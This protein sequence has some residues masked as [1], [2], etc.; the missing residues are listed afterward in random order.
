MDEITL[1]PIGTV[2]CSNLYKFEAPRQ[3]IYASGSQAQIHLEKDPGLIAALSDLA[4][5]ERIWVLF[6]FHQNHSWKPKVT[7]PVCGNKK[8]YGVFATRSPHRPNPI[9]LSCVTL[10]SVQENI[11][12]IA[13]HDL[14]DG[15]PVLDIKPYIPQVDSFPDSKAGWRDEIG[16]PVEVFF[17]EL[18]L[19]KSA[20]LQELCGL[21]LQNFCA[22]QLAYDPVSDDRKRV[23]KNAD[24]SYNIG[25]R[26]WQIRFLYDGKRVTVL[27]LFSHY[28]AEE[29]LP[30]SEDPYG[31]KEFH[32]T[33]L[34]EYDIHV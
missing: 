12:Q 18:F 28:T 8:R 3:G 16:E 21:S 6:L 14:L 17:E 2:H 9:G 10:L 11:L 26:T 27:D 4:G 33:F 19:Q 29:L 15:T 34:R 31:D 20:F 30:G 24:S 1:K 25:C 23:V 22:V 5:F 32:R 7:P 13:D